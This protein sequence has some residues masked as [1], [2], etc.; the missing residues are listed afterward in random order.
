[1][2]KA[3]AVVIGLVVIAAI[4]AA[5]ALL[6]HRRATR[7]ETL[8]QGL[9]DK[10]DLSARQERRLIAANQLAAGIMH[11]LLTPPPDLA[12]DSTILSPSHRREIQQWLKEHDLKS[13][14]YNNTQKDTTP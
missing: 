11:S 12:W 5:A 13:A 1:M 7:L 6:M 2:G 9:P 3:I 8:K 4:I 14:T 10:G